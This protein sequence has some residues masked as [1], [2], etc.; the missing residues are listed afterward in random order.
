LS[1][2]SSTDFS[3]WVSIRSWLDFQSKLTLSAVKAD[4]SVS[5]AF[6]LLDRLSPMDWAVFLPWEMFEREYEEVSGT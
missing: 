2:T 1:E 4:E 6:L 5:I 3:L